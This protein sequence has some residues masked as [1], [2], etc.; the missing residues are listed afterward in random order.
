MAGHLFTADLPARVCAK[1]G[2]SYFDDL[3][4]HSVELI[5]ALRRPIKGSGATD[6][7]N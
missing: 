7:D 2:T 6:R 3:G 1:C 4:F 5:T